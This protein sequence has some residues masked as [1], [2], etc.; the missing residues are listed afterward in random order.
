MS[1]ASTFTPKP[2]PIMLTASL[3]PM[4]L[5]TSAI[6]LAA[7]TS[8]ATSKSPKIRPSLVML[9]AE[10]LSVPPDDTLPLAVMVSVVT[11]PVTSM[12]ALKYDFRVLT[13]P[14]AN[15]H[16]SAI[17]WAMVLLAI[18][19]QSV[20]SLVRLAASVARAATA[21]ASALVAWV[22]SS[23]VAAVVALSA[24][25]AWSASSACPASAA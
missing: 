18:L 4:V 21:A 22:A 5:M 12:P 17:V 23:A 15:V 3:N 20:E 14:L 8:P 1:L 6:N 25:A 7:A 24:V 2:R 11:P 19:F 13:M 9:R 16:T 10:P